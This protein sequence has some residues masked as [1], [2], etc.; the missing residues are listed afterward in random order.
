V[1]KAHAIIVA[2]G[3][4]K[5]MGADIPKQLLKL[6]GKTILE[7]TLTPFADAEDIQGITIVSAKE[8]MEM[9]RNQAAQFLNSGKDISVVEG[10]AERQESVWNGIASVPEVVDIVLIHDAVRPFITTTLISE[11]IKSA[12]DN[13][14][15]T[16][17]RPLKETI[18]NVRDGIVVNTPDR[19]SLW[20]TQTPQAFK[21][22]IIREAHEKARAASFLGTDDC[23]L[24]ERLGIPVHIIEGNDY[25]IKITTPAD[26]NIAHAIA[27]L[28]SSGGR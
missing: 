27:P 1:I 5:R 17:M 15:A 2:G 19:S 12:S 21:V 4:G 10:G 9:I 28:F 14:A 11:C 20:I 8:S 23:M 3:I 24:V 26:L 13:G 6:K 18:K 7:W 25:N 22:K 16:V